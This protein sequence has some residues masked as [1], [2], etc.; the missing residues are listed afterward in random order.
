MLDP[1]D[2]PHL[3]EEQILQHFYAGLT[4]A[5]SDHLKSCRTCL[6]EM[7][8]LQRTLDHLSQWTPPPRAADYGACVWARISAR[9]VTRARSS[10]MRPALLGWAAL[11]A[12]AVAVAILLLI[13]K[14]G[15][16]IPPSPP[17]A[18]IPV[19]ERL[20]QIA[21]QDHVRRA[22]LLLATLETQPGKGLVKPSQRTAER[23][24]INNLVAENRLYRQ[25]AEQEDDL[26]T[27]QLLTDLETALV[28]LKHDPKQSSAKEFRDLRKRLTTVDP[29]G[30]WVGTGTPHT[31]SGAAHVR[32]IPL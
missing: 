24:A 9:R 1:Q 32:R 23:E 29:V 19:S 6:S 17:V 4:A 20:L 5:E 2:R 27:A 21:V 3:T 14:H 22:T 15:R 28:T 30:Q 31:T 12:A 26:R 18:A 16:F 10:K 7:E 8:S 25:T 11:I 13:P